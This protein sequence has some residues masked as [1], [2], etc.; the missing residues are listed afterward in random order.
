[1]LQ[2]YNHHDPQICY[3][4]KYSSHQPTKSIK[5]AKCQNKYSSKA[6]F[7]SF[8][9]KFQRRKAYAQELPYYGLKVDLTNYVAAYDTM[10][11]RPS[12]HSPA[13]PRQ[14]N[15]LQVRAF[16]LILSIHQGEMQHQHKLLILYATQTGNALDAAERLARE[17]ELPTIQ[18]ISPKLQPVTCTRTHQDRTNLQS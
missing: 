5:E 11:P 3:K 8:Q 4:S 14:S 13:E 1:M 17:T 15:K 9:V 6:Y 10:S 18:R 12:N 16:T 2:K 7:K